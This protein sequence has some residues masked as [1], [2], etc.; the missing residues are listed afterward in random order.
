[1]VKTVPSVRQ[2]NNLFKTLDSRLLADLFAQSVKALQQ[3]I[4]GLGKVVAYDF[5][6]TYANV[7]ENNFR[8]YVPERFKKDQQPIGDPDCRLGVKKSTNW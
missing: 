4:P 5:K 7:K 3:E 1:V 2:L 6:D 8:A